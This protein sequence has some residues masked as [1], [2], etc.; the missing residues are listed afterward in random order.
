LRYSPLG[1]LPANSVAISFYK[2][3][4]NPQGLVDPSP[5]YFAW[6]ST[7][8]RTAQ[9]FAGTWWLCPID[10]T[11]QYKVYISD[12]N[13]GGDSR[14]DDVDKAGCTRKSLAA[15]NANPFN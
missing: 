2:T 4:D 8:G 10:G 6:P 12:Y 7:E 1:W 15:I 11:S 3:G 14:Q 9:F 5:S 13:F